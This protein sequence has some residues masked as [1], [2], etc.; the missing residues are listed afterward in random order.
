MVDFSQQILPQ[1]NSTRILSFDN[2]QPD[3]FP[4]SPSRLNLPALLEA[5]VSLESDN[6]ESQTET[7]SYLIEGQILSISPNIVKVLASKDGK[8]YE[9]I[10]RCSSLPEKRCTFLVDATKFINEERVFYLR[11]YLF[12]D[13]L[14]SKEPADVKIERL[15][16]RGLKFV[17][18]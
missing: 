8:V 18:N 15:V 10:E 16:L 3:R 4:L 11:L 2:L 7:V 5:K 17:Q 13:S 9:E 6:V 14:F 12:A 1:Y